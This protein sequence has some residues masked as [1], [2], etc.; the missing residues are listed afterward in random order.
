M[1]YVTNITGAPP[2][3][4]TELPFRS[5]AAQDTF[6]PIRTASEEM[7]R[8]AQNSICHVLQDLDGSLFVEDVWRS[9]DGSTQY[10]DRVLRKG[11][12]FQ[13]VGANVAIIHSTFS[14]ETAQAATGGSLRIDRPLPFYVASLSLVIHAHN[15]MVP[16]AHAHYRYFEAGDD[17]APQ[18]WWFGGGADLTPNYLFEEDV[19]HFH[20]AHRDVCDRF[21]LSYY[22]RFKKW[23][24]EYFN[25]VHRGERR[26]VGG[27]FFDNLNDRDPESLFRFMTQCAEA[28]VPAYLPI[29]SRR[30][31][32]PFTAEHEHWRQLRAGRYIEFNLLYERGTVFGLKSGGRASSIL[33]GLPQ[34]ARWEYLQS[35]PAGSEEAR[36]VEV[37]SHPRDWA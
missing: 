1:T 37:L 4:G 12:V 26:G 25:I 22:P 19:A 21:D 7:V 29:V 11:N 23:C 16:S 3:F 13:I 2:Q 9:G 36:L 24:D 6:Q 15:P 28:F 35:P 18:Y 27:I 20:R 31:Q 34:Q 32:L 17:D 33:R 10:T 5:E 8:Q 30:C 14:P